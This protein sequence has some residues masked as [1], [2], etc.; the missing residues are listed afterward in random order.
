M[1]IKF[2]LGEEE[3]RVGEALEQVYIVKATQNIM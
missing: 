2:C 3:R 1:K